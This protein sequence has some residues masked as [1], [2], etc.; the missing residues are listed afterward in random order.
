MEDD[1]ILLPPTGSARQQASNSCGKGTAYTI[2]SL[3]GVLLLAGQAVTVYFVYQHDNQITKLNKNTQQLKLDSL[4]GS[5]SKNVQ[6]SG[7]KMAIANV[8]PLAL[9]EPEVKRTDTDP[10]RSMTYC[11]L[12]VLDSV[13]GF[14]QFTPI[15][16]KRLNCLSSYIAISKRENPTRN[17]PELK[18]N[19]MENMGHL[20]IHM[21]YNDWKEFETWMHKWLIFQLA[22]K[23]DNEKGKTKCQK[24]EC[25]KGVHPGKLCAHCDKKGNYLPMQ[26]HSGT[27]YCW[28]V[29]KD[30]TE[31]EGTKIRGRPDCTGITNQS[32]PTARPTRRLPKNGTLLQPPQGI[33]DPENATYSGDQY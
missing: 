16:E 26:C 14:S 30:G 7:P 3:L 13:V 1:H 10:F 22:Q 2:F 8:M 24:E 5:I 28:C 32:G 27:G 31:I 23:A 11:C 21:G 4:T 6:R 12:S 29:Y 18:S 20:K 25:V 33:L 17:F 15:R 19:F 9:N